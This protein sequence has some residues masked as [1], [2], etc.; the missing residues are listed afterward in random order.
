MRLTSPGEIVAA[1]A[2]VAGTVCEN[3]QAETDVVTHGSGYTVQ[4]RG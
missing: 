3:L 1:S 2:A 4:N